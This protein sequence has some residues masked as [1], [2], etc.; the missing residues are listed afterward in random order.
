MP[1]PELLHTTLADGASAKLEPGRLSA[2]VWQRA[3]MQ[4]RYYKPPRPDPQT[5]HDQ[6]EIYFVIDGTARFVCDGRVVAC[7]RGDV[8]FAAAGAAHRFDDPSGDFAVWV[9]FYGPH[10]GELPEAAKP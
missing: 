10:G 2:L 1:N 3:G 4:L 8:L 6:D 9:V 5:P 7:A